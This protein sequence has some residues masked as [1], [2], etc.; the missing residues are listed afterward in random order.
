VSTSRP[1]DIPIT[2]E[3]I[4]QAIASADSFGHEMRVRAILE[5]NGVKF[6]HGWTYP[7]PVE[8]KPRQ[9][10]FRG[11]LAHLNH[12]NRFRFAIECKN[13]APTAPLVISGTPRSPAE[14]FHDIVSPADMGTNFIIRRSRFENRVYPLGGFVGKSFLRLRLDKGVLVSSSQGEGDVYN[15]WAQALASAHEICGLAAK[16]IDSGVSVF[17]VI[18]P[19]VVVPDGTLWTV[20][21]Q[22]DSSIGAGAIAVDRASVFVN[23]SVRLPDGHQSI[24]L[25]HVEFF[26]LSGLQS[27][28]SELCRH[29]RYEE[30][31]FPANS[32]IRK[33]VNEQ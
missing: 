5:Q 8:A 16:D 28:L 3:L 30:D 11:T 27:F 32:E 17:S 31:W 23:H 19:A 2:A 18:L 9:F 10:D 33:A 14:A 6:T 1:A 25:S 20:Q 26:T 15:G 24:N 13:L 29:D 4:N 7:D 21:Y 12:R 22:R